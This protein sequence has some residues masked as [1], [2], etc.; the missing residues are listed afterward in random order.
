MLAQLTTFPT[1][2]KTLNASHL[3]VLL[4]NAKVL[5]KDIPHGELLAAVLKRRDMKVEELAKTAVSA[6]VANGTLVVW[7]MLDPE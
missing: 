3:L 2:P 6:N 4:T 1:L 5:A 7:A